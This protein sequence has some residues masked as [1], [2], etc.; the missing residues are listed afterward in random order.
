[1]RKGEE[2]DVGLQVEEARSHSRMDPVLVSDLGSGSVGCLATAGSGDQLFDQIV[3]YYSS[4]Q[5]DQ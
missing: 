2:V 4:L 1:M 5:M 3:R